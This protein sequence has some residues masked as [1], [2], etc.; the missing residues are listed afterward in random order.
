MAMASLHRQRSLE[1]AS[2]W[3]RMEVGAVKVLAPYVQ[4][5]SM[6]AMMTR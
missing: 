3:W 1:R 2:G 6:G 5:T 4:A